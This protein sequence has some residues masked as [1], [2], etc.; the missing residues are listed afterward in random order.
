M[1]LY[2]K[3]LLKSVIRKIKDNVTD[4]RYI[5]NQIKDREELA[6]KSIPHK[7]PSYGKSATGLRIYIGILRCII[8][9]DNKEVHYNNPFT[10]MGLK[11]LLRKWERAEAKRERKEEML[12]LINRVAE[13]CSSTTKGE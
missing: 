12:K 3:Q 2:R 6:H 11:W 8:T 10:V 9:I 5:H 1:N 13:L 7:E 4:W